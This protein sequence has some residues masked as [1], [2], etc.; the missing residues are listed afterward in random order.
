M[1]EH[2]IA[3][4]STPLGEATI[5]IVRLGGGEARPVPDFPQLGSSKVIPLIEP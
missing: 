4:I 3:V 1:H 5:G 2:T